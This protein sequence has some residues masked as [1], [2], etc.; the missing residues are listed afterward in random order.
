MY[1]EILELYRWCV[2]SHIRCELTT[3]YD[4]YKIGFADG[5]DFVQ[6]EGSYYSRYGYVEPA[7]FE[8]SY[9]PVTLEEA[10]ILIL[11][12]LANPIL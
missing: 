10:K 8:K 12:K 9:E 11:K 5:S 7:G 4:G 3:I 2:D 1:K 6:H